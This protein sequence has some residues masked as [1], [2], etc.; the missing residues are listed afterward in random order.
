VGPHSDL[1]LVGGGLANCLIA[2]RLRQRRPDLHIRILE[3]GPHLA[4]NHTWCFHTGDLSP[5]QHR[6]LAPLVAH[7]WP[8]QEVRFP[9]RRRTLETGYR[10]I[11]AQGLREAFEREGVAEVITGV[12][13]ERLSPYAVTLATG[14]EITA[15]GVIDGRGQRASHH[16]TL[17]YQKFLGREWRCARPHGQPHPLIMDATV[18]QDDGYRFVYVL[19]LSE[20]RLLIEDTYYSDT[21]DLDGQGVREAVTGYAEHQGW[22]LSELVREENGVLPILLAGD[23]D[24]FWAEGPGGVA[25]SGLAAG[26]FHPTTGY[27]L[28][29]AVRL[30]EAI[31]ASPELDGAVLHRLTRDQARHHWR[32]TGFFR[33]LNRMLFGAAP[34]PERYRVLERF[35]GL[36]RPLI[37][38][39][40]AGELKWRDRIRLLAGRPPVPLIPA[41]GC[42]SARNFPSQRATTHEQ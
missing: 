16:Q 13:A 40:Y 14:E 37:E 38:R 20:H 21:P 12:E 25:R 6:W 33:L 9:G 32:R 31:A 1:L 19:P 42:L 24:G 34:P 27:S 39:F 7:S 10:A 5:T 17:G 36:P 26:L 22:A 23:P 4:G 3:R 8:R 28:P 29:D 15:G 11:T 35:Y 2:W 30:A 18:P 41:L